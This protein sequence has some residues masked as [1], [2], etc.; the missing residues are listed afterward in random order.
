MMQRVN[1][2]DD[3]FLSALDLYTLL[4][5][6]FIGVAYLTTY[7]GMGGR[8]LELPTAAGDSTQ[9]SPMDMPVVRWVTTGLENGKCTVKFNPLGKL[10]GLIP[11]ATIEVPCRPAAFLGGE[12]GPDPTLALAAQRWRELNAGNDRVPRVAIACERV[13][14]ESCA[15]L[16]WVFGEAGFLTFAAVAGN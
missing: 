6:M 7:G 14:I 11:A 9:P 8:D 16:Q 15:R 13:D 3:L 1:S 2:R 12:R 5:L 10:A 4:S